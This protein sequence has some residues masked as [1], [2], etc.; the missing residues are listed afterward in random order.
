MV[1]PA[2]VVSTSRMKPAREAA[3]PELIDAHSTGL[4]MVMA[5]PSRTVRPGAAGHPWQRAL[6]P[7]VTREPRSAFE[8]EP[9]L[10]CCEVNALAAI[11]AFRTLRRKQGL[12]LG[13]SKA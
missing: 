13:H 8:R 4:R 5:A 3:G 7:L 11:R 12:K 2:A 9:T 6:W 10:P 1:Q